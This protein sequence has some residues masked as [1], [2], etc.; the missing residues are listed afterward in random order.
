MQDKT[1]T[2]DQIKELAL[3]YGIEYATL[4]AVIEVESKGHGFYADGSPIIL[5]EPHI[6]WKELDKINY[7]S[8][9]TKMQKMAPT[10]LYPKWKTYPYGPSSSQHSKL[11]QAKALVFK[12]LPKLD[13]CI[14]SDFV[15]VNKIEA[16]AI[17]STSWGLGQVMGFHWESLGYMSAHDF[18]MKMAESEL[19]QLDAMMRFCVKNNLIGALKEKNWATFANGYNGSSYKVNKYDTKLK[20]AY[21]SFK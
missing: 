10:L 16:A 19:N 14:N 4:R 5:F 1:L 12:V 2:Q 9:R 3:K 13:I 6:F 15:I 17:S 7:I 11:K 18:E 21:E 20:A 8:L